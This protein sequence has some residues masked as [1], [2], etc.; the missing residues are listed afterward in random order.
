MLFKNE[1]HEKE[2]E[3]TYIGEYPKSGLIAN[4]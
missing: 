4:N 2:Y 3:D 1:N